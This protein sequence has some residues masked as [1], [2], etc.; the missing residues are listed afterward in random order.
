MYSGGQSSGQV[1]VRSRQQGM[2]GGLHHTCALIMGFVSVSGV[3]GWWGVSGV[4]G[5]WGGVG[6][7]GVGWDGMGWDMI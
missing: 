2:V 6:W 7:D 5:G 3:G 4:R 1:G